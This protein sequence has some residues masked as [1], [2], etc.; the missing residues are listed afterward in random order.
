[1]PARSYVEPDVTKDWHK[2]DVKHVSDRGGGLCSIL[3]AFGCFCVCWGRVGF[4]PSLWTQK[5][6]CITSNVQHQHQE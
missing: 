1:M 6:N 4:W 5:R 2:L 3:P